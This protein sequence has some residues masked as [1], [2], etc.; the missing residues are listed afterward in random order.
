M[1][2]VNK[3]YRK[4]LDEVRSLL[5]NLGFVTKHNTD[6]TAWAVLALQDDKKRATKA[7]F[8]SLSRGATIRDILDFC[9]ESGTQYAENSRESLRKYSIK[10]LVHAGLAISN[11]DD[12][13]RPTNSAKTNYIL[14]PEFL[15][16]L[17]SER[18][19]RRKLIEQW[20]KYAKKSGA[21][22]WR[23][24][25]SL[26]VRFNGKKFSVHPSKHNLLE[27]CAIE[28]FLPAI[29]GEFDVLYFSD[30][31]NKSLHVTKDLEIFLESKFDV[32]KKM[33][34][35]VVYSKG[36]KTLFLIEAVAS[37]GEIDL[38]RKDEIDKLF[39]LQKGIERRYVSMFLDRKDF[40]RFSDS[41]TQGTEVWVVE[42]TPH[43][44]DI[45]PL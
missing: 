8:G 7:G 6:L 28:V 37:A 18:A 11:P 15:A 31:D 17:K 10:Y 24:D 33:P 30:T 29:C 22:E 38:L 39:P 42:E 41:I 4:Q 44:I 13:S 20:Q 36:T 14:H 5:R 23:R 26:E 34:D 35:I 16:I 25:K 45:S 19:Q 43:V 2:A 1:P 40:R 12:P 21:H 3:K 9:R 32:H 27:K